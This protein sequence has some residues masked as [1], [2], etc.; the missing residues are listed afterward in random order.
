M[1]FILNGATFSNNIG[2]VKIETGT[3]GGGSEPSTPVNPTNYVF[4]LN[5]IPTSATVTLTA[6]G[7]SAVSGTGSKSIT[8]ANGTKVNWSVSASGYTARTGD[9]TISGGNKTESITLTAA[10]GGGG[11]A[12][13]IDISSLF[14]SDWQQGAMIMDSTKANYPGPQTNQ[15]AYRCNK[16]WIDI[17]A[18]A[19]T[20][21]AGAKLQITMS[22]AV[23][24]AHQQ[25]GLIF[26]SEAVKDA[27]K[28]LGTLA[29]QY[30]P[31]DFQV[32]SVETREIE[33]PSG[34]KYVRTTWLPEAN[35]TT[36]GAVFSAKIIPN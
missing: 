28:V 24:T 26:Y 34:T 32:Y 8:V 12:A 5:P 7:Y 1:Y 25:Y 29:M 30:A 35:E 19:S 16:T 15:S 6:T 22:R 9:W 23:N 3:A 14:T 10:S 36:L 27:T 18:Y 13:E 11:G 17:S 20:I 21:N 4:T 31:T 33:I 2:T